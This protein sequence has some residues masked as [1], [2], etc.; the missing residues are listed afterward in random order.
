[1]KIIQPA[2]DAILLIK[3]ALA[4]PRWLLSLFSGLFGAR[5]SEERP[6]DSKQLPSPEESKNM[7]LNSP[8]GGIPF[9]KFIGM[10]A[11]QGGS[12][13]ERPSLPVFAFG[14]VGVTTNAQFERYLRH[15]HSLMGFALHDRG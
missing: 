1:M 7:R 6:N 12:G 2:L 9:G 15:E 8:P 3:D 5:G 14:S 11:P 10:G 4:W 13:I